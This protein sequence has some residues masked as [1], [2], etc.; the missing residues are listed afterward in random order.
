MIPDGATLMGSVISRVKPAQTGPQH[1]QN[2]DKKTQS[3]LMSTTMKKMFTY[4]IATTETNPGWVW[5]TN[6]QRVTL[7]GR[8][9]D[10]GT[11]QP[12]PRI[13]Q[14][15]SKKKI[16]YTH[17][18]LNTTMNG[19]T[20]SAVIVISILVRKVRNNCKRGVYVILMILLAW[21]RSLNVTLLVFEI[22]AYLRR[23]FH[24]LTLGRFNLT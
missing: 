17:W 6:Q 21:N 22:P 18:V 12:G 8:I 16:V 20:C 14:I 9:V 24:I 13:S 4:N 15:I 2:V 1:W 19:M 7:L 3:L 5:M 23:R 11:L 10:M